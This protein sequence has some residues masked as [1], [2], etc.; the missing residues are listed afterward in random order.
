MTILPP[1]HKNRS[2]IHSAWVWVIAAGV[3][4]TYGVIGLFTVTIP[5]VD[6]LISWIS[7]IPT[8]YI[9]IAAFVVIFLEGLYVLGSVFPGSSFTVLFAATAGLQ[10]PT[11]FILVITAIFIGWSL[12]GVV[13][14]IYANRIYRTEIVTKQQKPTHLWYTWFPAFRANQE[15][16]EVARGVPLHQVLSSSVTVKFFACLAVSGAAYSIPLF[17]NI[18]EIS[19]QDGFWGVIAFATFTLGIGLHRLY[20][21]KYYTV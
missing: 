18:N 15:V 20:K 8:T 13:N 21:L 7:S 19:A 12:S 4:Y 2:E 17:I 16:A 6:Q 5:G 9:V 3:M 1:S 11:Q 14:T 10:S